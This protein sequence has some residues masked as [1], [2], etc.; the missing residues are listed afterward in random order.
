M[1]V[2]DTLAATY[3]ASAS[4]TAGSVAEGAASRKDSKYSAIAQSHVFVPFAIYALDSIN[5]KELKFLSEFG[6][7][8]TAAAYDPQS[9]IIPVPE[10][11]NPHTAFQRCLL[12]RAL[13]PNLR[14]SNFSHSRTSFLHMFVTL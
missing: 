9:S 2:A 8:L 14:R 6:D 1:T 7:R 12:P 11:I 4:T 5:F 3:L 10:N 13:S